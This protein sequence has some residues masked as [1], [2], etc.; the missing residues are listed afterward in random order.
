MPGLKTSRTQAAPN[1]S[2]SANVRRVCS[3]LLGSC[4]GAARAFS[5]AQ[6]ATSLTWIRICG[7]SEGTNSFL[8]EDEEDDAAPVLP[9]PEN[10]SFRPAL[11]GKAGPHRHAGVQRAS[12]EGAK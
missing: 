1:V 11:D 6:N 8:L 3:F 10:Q 5:A 7:R 4:C 2:R 9:R 12:K